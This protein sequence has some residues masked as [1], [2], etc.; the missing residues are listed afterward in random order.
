M[1]TIGWILAALGVFG[2]FWLVWEEDFAA[3]SGYLYGM[4]GPK[5]EAAYCL[6]VMERIREIT[7][8]R[9]P[10]KLERHIDEQIGF[11]RARAGSVLGVGR[12]ALSRDSSAP[13]VEEKAYLHLAIQDCARR[14]VSFYGHKFRGFT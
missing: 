6:A 10:E 11:W 14:A 1:R 5:E 13:A 2:L 9:G 12:A 4:P 8:E 7:K 3:P